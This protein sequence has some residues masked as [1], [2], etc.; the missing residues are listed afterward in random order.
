VGSPR[1]QREGAH[2]RVPEGRQRSSSLEACRVR[3]THASI[4]ERRPHLNRQAERV[5]SM[6]PQVEDVIAGR[7]HQ[8]P[9]STDNPW[10]HPH[11]RAPEISD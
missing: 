6:A 4:I 11:H 2:V 1:S 3:G 10:R 7:E 5:L 9:P 8:G